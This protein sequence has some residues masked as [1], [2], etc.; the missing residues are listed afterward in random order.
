MKKNSFYQSVLFVILFLISIS[1]FGAQQKKI[2]IACVGNSITYGALIENRE[3]NSYPAQLATLLGNEYEV[4]NFGRGGATLL[5]K[6]DLPYW[7]CEEYRQAL[8]F[9][10]DIV[11]IKLGTNDSSPHNK[12]FFGDFVGDYKDLVKS[13]QDIPSHP[14]IVLLLPIPFFSRDVNFNGPVKD[15]PE[16]LS[17][18]VLPMVRQVAYETGCEIINLYN[19]LIE[20]PDLYLSDMVHP[21]AAGATVIAN[22]IYEFLKADTES[23]FDI[24]KTI[25]ADAKSFNFYGFQGYDFTFNGRQAF[26]VTP[27]KTAP[28][29]PWIWRARFWGHEPQADIALLERGFHVVYC[30]VAELFGNE[31]AL[32]IWNSFYQLMQQAGLAPKA[33]ME[34]MSRGGVYIYR[35]AAK[36]PERVAAIY[37]DAPVLDL[38]SWPGGKGKSAGSDED[39]AVFKKDFDLKTEEQALAFNGN[40]LDLTEQ[41]AHGGFPLLHVVGE[42]DDVVPVDENT[43]PFEQKILALGGN[44]HVIHKQGIGHH[45]HSLPN[46]QPI[47]DFVLS[48]VSSVQNKQSFEI[49]DGHFIHNGRVTPIISGEM[50]YFRVP[51]QYWRHRMKMMKAMG[52]NTV[53]TYI[54]WNIHEPEPGV[55]DF[56]GDKDLAGFIKTAGEEGLMVILRPGPYICA[57]WEFGGYP[58]WLQ[59][60]KGMEVRC[61]N[62]EF[63]SHTKIYINRLFQEIGNL[64]ITKNGPVVMIQSENEFGSYVAQ[65]KDIPLAEHRAYNAKI[66]QQLIDAGFDV[67]FFTSDGSWLFEGG[68]TKGALPTANGEDSIENLKKVVNEYNGGKGPYM[69]AEF[70]PGMLSHWVEPFPKVDASK[71]ARQTEKY[72]I[73]DVSFNFYM[74]HGG[75]NFGFT[76]GAN[77]DKNHDIQPDLTSYDYDAPINEAGWATPKF[78]TIRNI[79]K[80]Y[81][82]YRVPE[83]PAALPVIAIPS[84]KLDKV[85]DMLDYS[86]KLPKIENAQ[87][88]TFEQLNQGYGYVLYERHFNQPINGKLEI[89]GLRDYAVVYVDGVKVGE[90]NRYFKSYALDIDIPFNAT[91]EILVENMGRINYGSE[92]VHN[93]KGIISPVTI[94]G[95]KIEGNWAMTK[96]PMSEV[97]DLKTFKK[98]AVYSNTLNNAQKL[99]DKPVAYEGSFLLK[100]TGDTFIDMTGWGKGIIFINGKN[101]GRYWHVGSQQTL[102]IPGVWLNKGE[103]KIVIFEQLNSTSKSEVKTVN[104]PV[105]NDLKD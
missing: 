5:R 52:L 103:N 56:S 33:V 68:V 14:R 9:R 45:P 23:T 60:I 77:Y 54:S 85:A 41:I 35:W 15:R 92:I 79:I 10:P 40:P 27:K 61:D 94:N 20:S 2:R 65:R 51:H 46:P 8:A 64:Q 18:Q 13:F 32:S 98:T 39:W 74:V 6:G 86:S 84:I 26:V 57:E 44:I 93:N 28:N 37:A 91:L 19:L 49:K 25:P 100:D 102:F 58:W 59:N 30:D 48:A 42:E 88:L 47:V 31:K 72:L 95:I 63:L 101:I 38:K 82:K 105:L 12:A 21:S 96:L 78:D 34:G 36:Y 97:P 53:C 83:A 70:Y 90:L 89:N 76:S 22:R 50:H 62:P 75:T 71:I 104:E 73:N 55:W 16:V 24:S 29:H 99:R 11:F 80:K 66:R 3:I 69:V 43:R 87:P 4:G 67:P 1:T 7:D 17:N 81:V